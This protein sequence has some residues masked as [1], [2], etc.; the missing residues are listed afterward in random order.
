MVE[1]LEILC[2]AHVILQMV[3]EAIT[4]S[5]HLF[6]RRCPSVFTDTGGVLGQ[7]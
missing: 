5:R 2:L 1:Q 3:V 6:I 4:H 7:T